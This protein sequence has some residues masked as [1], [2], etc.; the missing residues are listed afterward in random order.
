MIRQKVPTRQDGDLTV[1]YE[2]FTGV[3][4][5]Y[6]GGEKIYQKTIPECEKTLPHILW[7]QIKQNQNVRYVI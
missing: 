5:F 6:W 2:S 7:Y 4:H 1:Q 3:M